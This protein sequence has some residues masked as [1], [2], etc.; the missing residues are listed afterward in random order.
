MCPPNTL[1]PLSL[2]PYVPLC[3]PISRSS[4]VRVILCTHLSVTQQTPASTTIPARAPAK[5][6]D[7]DA[8]CAN[9]P[10][11][12]K[13]RVSPKPPPLPPLSRNHHHYHRY[14]DHCHRYTKVL[15]EIGNEQ[16][17]SDDLLSDVL[18]VAGA[19]QS[20]VEELKLPF[21]L[22]LA[23]GGNVWATDDVAKFAKAIDSDPKVHFIQYST[24]LLN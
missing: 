16:S 14:Y 4:P 20:K 2:H 13:P 15:F 6:L 22:S 24:I 19:M 9:T 18:R 3:A 7:A 21:N 12:A 11:D 10:S 23:V 5:L 1:L 8:L 17:L